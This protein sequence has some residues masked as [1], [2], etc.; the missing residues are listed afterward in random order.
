MSPLGRQNIQKDASDLRVLMN[1]TGGSTGSFEFRYRLSAATIVGATSATLNIPYPVAT[2]Y[3][4][5]MVV[6]PMTVECE[7]RRITA[8]SGSTY[9]FAALAY[10]HAASDLVF[11]IE[12]P[13]L[14]L[15]WFGG[16]P[17]AGVTDN[18]TAI[19]RGL[20]QASGAGGG[21]AKLI[22]TP[23]IFDTSGKVTVPVGVELGGLTPIGTTG[24][25]SKCCIRA[26]SGFPGST[27]LI[28]LGTTGSYQNGLRLSGLLIDCAQRASIG[29]YTEVAAEHSKV[30]NC[31]IIDAT[32]KG[33]FFDSS[34]TGRYASN[35]FIEKLTVTFPNAA[36]TEIG[37][38]IIGGA[39][40]SGNFSNQHGGSNI[41]I[42]ASTAINA[43]ILLENYAGGMWDRV[44]CEWC[45]DGIRVN[46]GRSI[47]LSN[48]YGVNTTDVIDIANEPA[49]DAINIISAFRSG[50][51]NIINDHLNN[52]AIT[53]TRVASYQIGE[54]YQGGILHNP[55]WV[56]RQAFMKNIADTEPP[57]PELVF[58]I[59]TTDETGSNDSGAYACFVK[60]VIT[61]PQASGTGTPVASK[62]FMA[63]FTR[64]MGASGFGS[65]SAVSEIVE[66]ASAA[67]LP[68]TRD[69]GAVT[70]TVAEIDEY[71]V[72]VYF[73]CD[74]T[75]TSAT[76][77]EI[78]GEVELIWTNFMTSPTIA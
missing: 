22:V 70:M 19:D 46:S 59:T 74:M 72:G 5:W 39:S 2:G 3:Q 47:T 32:S 53:T 25:I 68:A 29:V 78:M 44:H 6:D 40:P 55:P 57:V 30:G 33:L 52:K 75:G 76:N 49:I 14:P 77:Y 37:V 41:T 26:K 54:I 9:S 58:T 67:N 24:E 62:A 60:A 15:I 73:T 43:G 8:V 18:V 27:P 31:W 23:G 63:T 66:T 20:V 69:I 34:P 64:A 38:H 10:A 51:T 4:T 1:L 56:I 48:I 12:N 17:D 36:G 11:F 21:A 45:T 50:G 28:Q 71:N 42:N 35:N 65:N 7:V 16:K 61:Q 13:W